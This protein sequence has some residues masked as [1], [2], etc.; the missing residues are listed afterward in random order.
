MAVN[1]NAWFLNVVIKGVWSLIGEAALNTCYSIY[2]I[3]YN[4][5][6]TIMDDRTPNINKNTNTRNKA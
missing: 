6:D 5:K 4:G 2:Y 1:R 3:I